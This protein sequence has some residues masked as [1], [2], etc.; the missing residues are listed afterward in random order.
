VC[1]A[2]TTECSGALATRCSSAPGASGD[3]SRVEVCNGADDDCDGVSDEGFAV[4]A[5]CT[6]PGVCDG[7][8]WECDDA[9]G[10][11][12]CSTAPGG[13]DDRATPEVCDGEDDDC[14]GATD[15]DFGVGA[16]CVAS[17]VCGA[18]VIECAGASDVRCSTAPG[19]SA[20]RSGPEACDALDNDCDGATDEGFGLGG[21]CHAAGECGEGT[22]E[23]AGPARTRCSSEPGGSADRSRAEVCN[24]RDDD[25]DA[26]TD[27][28]FGVGTTCPG[29]G[30]C[31]DG[32]LECA[33]L[34]AT[35][36]STLPGGSAS[37]AGPDACDGLDNDCDGMTDEAF[38]LGAACAAPGLCGA[39]VTECA[40]LLTTR[41]STAPGASGDRSV[42]EVC[43][44]ADNDCDG[45]VDEPFGVGTPCD[46][47]GHCGMGVVECAQGGG[48]RCSSAPGSS[49]DDSTPE[50]CDGVDN[51]CDGFVDEGYGVG[52]ACVGRGL[53]PNGVLECAGEDG[54]EVVCSTWPGG[55]RYAGR[56][57]TCDGADEDCDGATDE[58]FGAGG[59]CNLPGVCGAGT[60]VCSGPAATAC[61][62][63]AAAGDE[64]CDGLDNDCDGES[65]EGFAVGAACDGPGECGAGATECAGAGLVCS[66]APGGSR[67]MSAP[68][69]CD[70][71]DNDCDGTVPE[72]EVDRDGDLFPPCAG[73]CDEA[74]RLVSPALAD[75]CD[76][77]DND[78]DG[79]ID[80][81]GAAGVCRFG[82]PCVDG[83]AC[84][85]DLAC[86]AAQ[87][88]L[89]GGHATM[90]TRWCSNSSDRPGAP[91]RGA[92]NV[93]YAC[94]P[95]SGGDGHGTCW[96]GAGTQTVGFACTRPEECASLDCRE[97]R[98]SD[99]CSLESH[100]TYFGT[101]QSYTCRT[102]VDGGGAVRGRCAPPLGAGD[103]GA[104]CTSDADCRQGLCDA[105]GMCRRLCC[106]P[107][108]CAAGRACLQVAGAAGSA[109]RACGLAP[110]GS[111][112]DGT[113]CSDGATCAGGM[114]AAVAQSAGTVCTRACCRDEDCPAGTCDVRALGPAGT[115]GRVCV[116][117][118]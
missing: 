106:A 36:C 32:V 4:G 74:D 35:R 41:C 99:V 57:E 39:G 29:R 116:P 84:G 22:L 24:G 79:A 94:L 70:G 11:R 9:A 76:G 23:C 49:G 20:D 81:T 110:A 17:G 101:V 50:R 45:E 26:Q 56:A 64:R 34:L 8:A 2:G 25:C 63:R 118:R 48:T 60:R 28:G 89:A 19:A 21:V 54:D 1:G 83:A 68:E 78:C 47:G 46:A 85:A 112:V 82:E 40:T 30:T 72:G 53:C 117:P 13:S 95:R 61:S 90:C 10:A 14:D 87:V 86:L 7:G 52:L 38:R 44:A 67:D 51:D 62:S 102:F 66:T 105:S 107:R 111:G 5:A 33:G 108:D 88:P 31:G 93:G 18:G 115:L 100:C 104:R 16:T 75:V 71:L 103:H 15:E 27:D 77:R 73:D 98:C 58:D 114:C 65:D 80:R 37:Q 42:P 97:G 55:S 91:P 3:R 109:V 12:R 59:A 113:A 92:C 43:D 6:A 96:P 69:R